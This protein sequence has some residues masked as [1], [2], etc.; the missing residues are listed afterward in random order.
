MEEKDVE[1]RSEDVQEVLG[2][3]PPWILRWGIS[4]LAGIVLFLI[5][6]SWMFKYPDI[7]SAPLVLTTT[8]PPASIIARTS[9]K[10]SM[11]FVNNQQTVMAGDSMAILENPANYEDIIY[12]RTEL[13]MINEAINNGTNYHL[14]RK[15][16]KLGA[17]QASFSGLLIRLENYNQFITQ[18]FHPQKIASM[19][20]II[21]AN[22][23]HYKSLISQQEIVK[24]QH[25]LE[26]KSF[27]RISYLLKQG[28]ISEEE[29]EKA[30][31]TLL[32]SEMNVRNMKS[33]L[34]NA[35]VQISQL[36]DNLIETELQYTDKRHT[37]LSELKASL[38]QLENE[39][40]TWE[41]TYV[42]KT[43]V[44][45]KVTFTN[46]WNV[47][48]N[49]SGGD[50][51][52]NVVPDTLSELVGKVQLPI[53]RSGKV[54]TGQQ[55]N[56][57][58]SNYPDNEYGIVKAQIKN[59]SLIPTK[60]GYFVAEVSFPDG[61]T[62]SYGKNLPLTHEMTATANIITDDLRLIEQFIQPL[63]KILKNNL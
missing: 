36:E 3:V 11:L 17:I 51:V 50:I 45:G 23:L 47:N 13:D 52:F 53:N 25:E 7:I 18:N 1:L 38:T 44:T 42:L 8:T 60:D 4:L 41:M 63:K 35:Q 40:R 14:P 5:A 24:K 49:V 54:K 20:R 57:L 21:E 27:N 48:Q 33:T 22:K 56:V 2:S 26:M 32:Q 12:I 58:F 62:T 34:E 9:A 43:P 61:L 19:R 59:I 15:N 28:L 30:Q 10:I 37:L 46:Y 31:S 39:I 55:V 16:L 29:G 6:G